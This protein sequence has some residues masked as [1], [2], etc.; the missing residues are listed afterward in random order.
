[1]TLGELAALPEGQAVFV[2]TVAAKSRRT[3]MPV[4]DQASVLPE[5]AEKR[6]LS[7]STQKAR[8]EVDN[9]LDIASVLLR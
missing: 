9:A 1:M 4:A 8:P 2:R 3:D 6:F 5:G 7:L